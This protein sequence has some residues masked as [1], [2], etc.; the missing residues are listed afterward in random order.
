[1]PKHNLWWQELQQNIDLWLAEHENGL[2]NEDKRYEKWL[3]SAAENSWILQIYSIK[4][5][6]KHLKSA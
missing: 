2:Y 5:T 3:I 4:R 1:M 6:I